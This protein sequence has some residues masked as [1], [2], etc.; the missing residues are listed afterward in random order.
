MP[1]MTSLTSDLPT[2]LIVDKWHDI[3]PSVP[4]ITP[5]REATEPVV[6]RIN[7]ALNRRSA[8]S[9]WRWIV[10]G[11]LGAAGLVALVAIVKR[12]RADEDATTDDQPVRLAS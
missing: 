6:E 10:I 3:A 5:L 11:A 2:D 8:S 7:E 9:R 4:D 1:D 12:R